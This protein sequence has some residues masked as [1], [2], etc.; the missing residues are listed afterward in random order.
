MAKYSDAVLVG[1]IMGGTAWQGMS[2]DQLIDSWGK[3]VE[4]GERVY[5]TKVVETCKYNQ[6]GSN[7][8]ASRVTVE[9]GVVTGWERK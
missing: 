7:R 3:P 9:N 2:K 8:F 6:T 1:R 5:K 4:I